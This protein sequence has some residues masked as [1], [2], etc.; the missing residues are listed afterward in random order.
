MVMTETGG[1]PRIRQLPGPW[2]ALGPIKFV[3]PNIH[4]VYLHGTPATALFNRARRDFS[5]GCVRLADPFALA[6]WVLQDERDWGA[7]RIRAAVDE[8]VTRSIE[9]GRPPHVVLFYMTAAYFPEDAA[10]RFVD[11]VYGHDAR[12]DAWLRA[13]TEG[14]ER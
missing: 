9:V 13:D 14:G 1:S 8:G 3:L 2:N 5:H 7:D 10:I 12:L 6:S 4:G 11:D